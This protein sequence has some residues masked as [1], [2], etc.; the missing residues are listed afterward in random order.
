MISSFFAAVVSKRF[1]MGNICQEG[2]IKEISAHLSCAIYYMME[3]GT[4]FQNLTTKQPF[5]GKLFPLTAF[6]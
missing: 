5:Y 2:V 4:V 1:R 6:L 3:Y